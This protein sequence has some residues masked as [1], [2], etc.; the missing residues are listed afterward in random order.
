MDDNGLIVAYLLDGKGG[1]KSLNWQEINAWDPSQGL[2]WIHLNY[3]DRNAQ[4][5]LKKHSGLDHTIVEAM[6]I[7][8]SRPRCTISPDHVLIFFR[9]VN[10]NPG[11]DPE[12]MVSIR[13]FLEKN[14]IIST[15]KRRLLSIDDIRH[16]I[17]N[18]IGPKSSGE[19]ITILNE[20]LTNRISNVVDTMDDT[21]DRLE[22]NILTE[23]RVI[24]RTSISELRREVISIRRFLAPQREA[25][26]QLYIA[27]SK[28]LKADDRIHLREHTDR[29]IKFI[30]D[31]DSIRDRAAVLQEELSSRI[32]EKTDQRMYVL[33]LVASIFLPLSFVTGLLGINVA[34]IPGATYK[35]AFLIVC[36][37]LGVCAFFTFLILKRK[38]WI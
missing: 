1:G 21:M 25:L 18:N 26:N 4:G 24:L 11:A 36:L 37:L 38:K 10:L 8:E 30:E 5:W 19:F 7:E 16:M 23:N 13:V 33:S 29:V 2:L 32:A 27:D 6:T 31:L 34:G 22:E 12:D 15:R 9:G 35:G 28:L 14:R 3:Q 17:K 20:R